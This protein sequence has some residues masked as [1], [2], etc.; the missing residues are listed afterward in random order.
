MNRSPE[1][2]EFQMRE[3]SIVSSAKLLFLVFD[4]M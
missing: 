4:F 2:D 1:D 3:F